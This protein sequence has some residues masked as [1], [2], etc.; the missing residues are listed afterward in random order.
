MKEFLPFSISTVNW[1][2]FILLIIVS[3]SF[4]TPSSLNNKEQICLQVLN[5]SLDS[6]NDRDDR[7]LRS[8]FIVDTDNN[9]IYASRVCVCEFVSNMKTR[10]T[11]MALWVSFTFMTGDVQFSQ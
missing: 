10:E 2:L 6:S 4:C 3:C 11:P 1:I 5:S 9:V 7:D 8:I